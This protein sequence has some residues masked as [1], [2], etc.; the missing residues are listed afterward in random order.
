MRHVEFGV[1]TCVLFIGILVVDLN[2][3]AQ[4]SPLHGTRAVNGRGGMSCTNAFALLSCDQC[5]NALFG[6]GK[7]TT[8]GTEWECR[9]VFGPCLDCSITSA[10]VVCGG[11]YEVW[12]TQNNCPGPPDS[13]I[14]GCQRKKNTSTVTGCSGFCG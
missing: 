7:C 9:T 5:V 1:L 8:T 2:G 14:P 4:F 13:T 6:S 3:A 11:S 12:N 10:P